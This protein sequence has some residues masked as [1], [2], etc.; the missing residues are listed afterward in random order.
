MKPGIIL[1]LERLPNS[2]S[3][4]ANNGDQVYTAQN[5]RTG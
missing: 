2:F 1:I 3:A 5:T 4:S